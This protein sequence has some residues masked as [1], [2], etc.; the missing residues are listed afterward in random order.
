MKYYFHDMDTVLGFGQ[1]KGE[2]VRSAIKQY[3]GYI[4]WCLINVKSFIIS[5]EV[6]WN[7]PI[8]QSLKSNLNNPKIVEGL[9]KYID[10][11]NTKKLKYQNYLNFIKKKN[12]EDDFWDNDFYDS[13]T[14]KYGGYNGFDDFTIDE[15]FDGDPEATWNVD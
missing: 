12:Y 1:Y 10:L 7:L 3:P 2:T 8:I 6:F 13:G 14:T 9:K 5:D 4:P 11:Q 15:A